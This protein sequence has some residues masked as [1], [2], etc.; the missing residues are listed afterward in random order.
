MRCPRG[1][2]LGRGGEVDDTDQDAHDPTSPA[3]ERP[4]RIAGRRRSESWSAQRQAHPKG[5][6]RIAL[7]TATTAITTRRCSP[8]ISAWPSRVPR[9]AYRATP[10]TELTAAIA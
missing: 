4:H 7:D 5:S 2:G 3:D 6:T 1:S 8:S 9:R 10:T